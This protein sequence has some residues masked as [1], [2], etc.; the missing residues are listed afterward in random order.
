MTVG[1]MLDRISSTELAAWSVYERDYGVLGPSRDDQLAALVASTVANA[2]SKRKSKP[3][4]FMPRWGS[5]GGR[6]QSGR[7]QLA[8]FRQFVDRHRKR[9]REEG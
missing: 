1:E 7:E 9:E 2:M 6:K 3:A 4:D 8:M 5:R